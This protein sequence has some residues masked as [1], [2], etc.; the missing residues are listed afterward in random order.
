MLQSF[1]VYAGIPCILFATGEIVKILPMH[2]Q[3]G[4]LGAPEGVTMR[5]FKFGAL[6]FVIWTYGSEPLDIMIAQGDWLAFSAQLQ[7]EVREQN[8]WCKDQ[9]E[10]YTI[11][12]KPLPI[13]WG[14]Q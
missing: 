11:E 12:N 8:V 7:C 13:P 2:H 1:V 14:L 10:W 9:S 3:R 4:L 6:A 5:T